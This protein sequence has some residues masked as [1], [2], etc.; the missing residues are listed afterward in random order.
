MKRVFEVVITISITIMVV[1]GFQKLIENKREKEEIEEEEKN[2]KISKEIDIFEYH[3]CG[4]FS[5]KKEKKHDIF[6]YRVKK[7]DNLTKIV[8][9]IKKSC[10]PKF[11]Y[12]NF[13]KYQGVFGFNIPGTV[14]HPGFLLAIPIEKSKRIV[15]KEKF[16]AEAD[17]AIEE[18]KKNPK[19]G[20]RFSRFMKT[21]SKE[22]VKRSAYAY[23]M[24]ESELGVY[25]LNRW[26]KKYKAYSFSYF[27]VLMGKRGV[28]G[29]DARINLR[30][31]EGD[32]ILSPKNSVKLFIAY[33]L[34]KDKKSEEC[35][36]LSEKNIKDCGTKYNG[37]EAYYLNLKKFYNQWP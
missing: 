11:Q 7:N 12:L 25:A 3:D 8:D 27:H 32:I 24:A 5:L 14:I 18:M 34:E 31:S 21:V 36:A 17:E 29:F 1:I 23:A 37:N 4:T 26:E 16:L 9:K 10:G 20:K 2:D 13:E 15:S 19:Y 6:F 33:W 30:L 35:L 28:P 22:K